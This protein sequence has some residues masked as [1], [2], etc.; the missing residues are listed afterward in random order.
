MG[1]TRRDIAKRVEAVFR[2]AG[3]QTP[4]LDGVAQELR[5][6]AKAL[7]EAIGLLL[8]EKKLVKVTEEILMHE[9][10]LAPLRAKVRDY[11]KDGAKMGMPEFKEISGVSR[12]YSVPLLEYFDRSGLTIRVGD[13]RVLRKSAG[14]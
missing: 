6:E 13:Q 2:R 11:L 7:R 8:A 10:H 9:E 4:A 12:K 1:A 5:I 3:L 14:A